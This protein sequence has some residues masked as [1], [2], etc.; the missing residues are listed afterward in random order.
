MKISIVTAVYNREA[1]VAD[2][3][4]SVQQQTYR[5]IDH[6][7][8]DGGST[9][10]TLEIIK[11]RED[12]RTVL[13]SEPDRGIYDALNRGMGRAT[14]DIVGL[15][16]SDD[17]FAHTNV[18]AQVAHAFEDPETDCV[19]GDLQYVAANDTNHIIRQWKSGP[20]N[21]ELLRHGWMPPHPT[22]YVRRTVL[23]RLGD[24]DTSYQIAADYDAMLRWLWTGSI[25][26][27]Y[28]PDVMVKMR[29]GGESNRSLCRILK[30]S[31]EDYRALRSNRVGGFR[32]L[33]K[34]N[35]SKI[36]QFRFHK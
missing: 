1:T 16:H 11:S 7:I 23:E 33:A 35:I 18:V 25:R 21:R 9:D 22:F 28:I 24:Y 10:N 6:V 5:N 15:M 30:K 20:Y 31:Q 34:K 4:Q 19:Y 29:V 2:A 32:T 26:A 13:V 36:R 12:A 3:I 27:T 8:Q 14:G 17:I